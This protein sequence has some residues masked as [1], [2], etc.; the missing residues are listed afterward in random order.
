[1]WC[2]R[3]PAVGPS[4]LERVQR[5]P[6]PAVADAVHV[7]L[8]ALGVEPGDVRRSASGSTKEWPALSVGVAAAVEVRRG[9]R[10]RAV[11]GDAVLHHLDAGRAEPA[12]GVLRP[13]LDQRLDLLLAPVAVP[14]QRPDDVGGEVAALRGQRRYVG[15]GSSMPA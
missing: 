6:H 10:G 15:P 5:L 4:R 9:Q 13:P 1:M 8:E 3:S 2:R 7:H 11:L 14:P 12:V